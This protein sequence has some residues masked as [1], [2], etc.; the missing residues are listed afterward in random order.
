MR[1]LY[2]II[3]L[4]VA[5]VMARRLA[6]R[7]ERLAAHARRISAGESLGQW[8]RANIT[9]FKELAGDL[10]QMAEKI[11][12]ENFSQFVAMH[13]LMKDG[14]REGAK[15]IAD[16]LG[17]ERSMNRRGHSDLRGRTA[18]RRIAKGG[19]GSRHCDGDR[20]LRAV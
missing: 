5:I 15:A 3:I 19:G 11:T 17:L 9:E 2:F 12:E 14:D 7:F 16:E 6:P 10:Q 4:L 13:Q 1:I 18:W 8:P 20:P